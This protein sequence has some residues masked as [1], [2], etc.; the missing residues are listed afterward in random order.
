MATKRIYT[1]E[2]VRLVS[3]IHEYVKSVDTIIPARKIKN[4]AIMIACEQLRALLLTEAYDPTEDVIN[5]Q[6]HTP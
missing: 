2:E 4:I 5:G 1:N 3:A 6:A